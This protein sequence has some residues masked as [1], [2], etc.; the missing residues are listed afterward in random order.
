MNTIIDEADYGP[1]AQLIGTWAGSKGLDDAPGAN[2]KPDK[3][4]FT[5]E[6]VFTTS[7]PAGNAKEQSLVSIKYHHVVRKLESGA[8]FHDQTGHWIYEKSTNIIMHSLSIPRA[9]CLLAG[10]ELQQSNG[11]SIFN[12]AAEAGSQTYGIVQSPFMLEKA[13]TKAFK[14]SLSVKGDE[15]NYYETMSLHIYGKDFEHTDKSTL[16]R[17]K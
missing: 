11:E 3:T 4:A 10:G 8:I 16:F 13:K 15:L 5:D 7:G 2:A 12:V 17:V 6:M 1:L 14:M 9:V